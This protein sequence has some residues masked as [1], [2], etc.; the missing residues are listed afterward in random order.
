MWR[1][2]EISFFEAFEGK[3]VM[4]GFRACRKWLQHVKQIGIKCAHDVFMTSLVT[5]KSLFP[6][7]MTQ[8]SL[9]A[10]TM[11]EIMWY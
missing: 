1:R 6:I 9:L 4:L 3:G 5:S 2:I 10:Q 8:F 11:I 7:S